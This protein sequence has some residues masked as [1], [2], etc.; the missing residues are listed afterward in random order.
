MRFFIPKVIIGKR[1]TK[2]N[3]KHQREPIAPPP[4]L[5]PLP[6]GAHWLL[7]EFLIPRSCFKV[8]Y[9]GNRLVGMCLSLL[10]ARLA[11]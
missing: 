5:L 7:G 11:T 9:P 8:L 3:P 4:A 10:N 6:N 1:T 2:A